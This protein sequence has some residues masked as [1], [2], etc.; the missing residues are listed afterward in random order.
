MNQEQPPTYG[1]DP[2]KMYTIPEVLAKLR[3]SETTLREWR[4]RPTPL[5]C[6]TVGKIVR[7]SGYHLIRFMD[8]HH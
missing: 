3:I 6:F 2:N 7:I 8:G 5:K 4:N 1:L